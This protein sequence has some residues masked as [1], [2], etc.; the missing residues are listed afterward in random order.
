MTTETKLDT[1]QDIHEI[2][3]EMDEQEF[4]DKRSKEYKEYCKTWNTLAEK[5]NKLR[6]EKIWIKK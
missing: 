4:K 1:W 2:L 5:C 3:I 6:G